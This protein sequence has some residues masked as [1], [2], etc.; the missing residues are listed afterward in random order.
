LQGVI[1]S[2][3]GTAP[4]DSGESRLD[5]AMDALEIAWSAIQSDSVVAAGW[6][7]FIESVRVQ[8]RRQYPRDTL[9]VN[10]GINFVGEVV[11]DIYGPAFRAMSTIG[12]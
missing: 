8:L 7:V 3:L 11:G 4:G 5:A 6:N 9:L 10:F 2:L 1:R 12:R